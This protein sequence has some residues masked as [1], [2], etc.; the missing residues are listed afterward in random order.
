MC[1]GDCYSQAPLQRKPKGSPEMCSPLRPQDMLLLPS[2]QCASVRGLAHMHR[3]A[4]C[5]W[6]MVLPFPTTE[7][8]MWHFDSEGWIFPDGEGRDLQLRFPL[9]DAPPKLPLRPPGACW[10]GG[11]CRRSG[12]EAQT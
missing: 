7:A 11:G 3:T 2:W 10:A 1:F 6:P 8:S 9:E 5:A 12:N 4:A